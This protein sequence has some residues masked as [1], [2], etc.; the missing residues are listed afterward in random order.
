MKFK[1]LHPLALFCLIITIVPGCCKNYIPWIQ[2]VFDQGHKV[3]K[4]V[5][6]ARQYVRNIHVY[7]QFTT[8]GHFSAIWLSP[9][10][11]KAYANVYAVKHGFSEER[12][13]IFLRR[14]F[15]ENKHFISFIVLSSIP[16]GGYGYI[17]SDK[18]SPWS[19]VLNI[20]GH[21][22]KPVEIKS[23]EL[24]PEYRMFFGRTYTRFKLPYIIKFDAHD[25]NGNRLIAQ[26]TSQISL[27]F[28]RVDRY[29]DAVWNLEYNNKVIYEE[30][31]NNNVLL[32]DLYNF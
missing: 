6:V 9:E 5:D 11:R 2:N 28:A 10:V 16:N 29:E 31:P 27:R 25:I 19:V 15:E 24:S 1:S 23:I 26:G 3:D 22:F 17:L 7:D 20:D 14:Q 8:L 30:V 18:D 13:K 4:H 12:Y 32:Y 21:T